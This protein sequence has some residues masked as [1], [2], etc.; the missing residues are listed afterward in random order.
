[1]EDNCTDGYIYRR[2]YSSL[3]EMHFKFAGLFKLVTFVFVA[4]AFVGAAQVRDLKG[5]LALMVLLERPYE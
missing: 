1:V 4:I 3:I 5:P 2:K